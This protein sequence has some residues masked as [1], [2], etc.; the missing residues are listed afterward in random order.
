MRKKKVTL[1][2]FKGEIIVTKKLIVKALPHK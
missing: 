2:A 1:K